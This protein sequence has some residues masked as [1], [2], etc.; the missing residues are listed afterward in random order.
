MTQHV[1]EMQTY[2][3]REKNINTGNWFS[4][5][6]WSFT[7][8][9]VFTTSFS[10]KVIY[11]YFRILQHIEGKIRERIGDRHNNK[12]L[13]TQPTTLTQNNIASE[14]GLRSTYWV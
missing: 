13:Y 5:W 1:L 10:D 11:G 8:V 2:Y 4:T 9:Y 6:E 14:S 3:Q 7:I 12:N